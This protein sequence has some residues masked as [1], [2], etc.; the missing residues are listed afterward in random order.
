MVY[1]FMDDEACPTIICDEDSDVEDE[2][3]VEELNEDG[4]LA[5][6]IVSDE[7][8]VWDDV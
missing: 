6:F 3:D 2:S 7:L 8:D 1:R 4:D 5:D